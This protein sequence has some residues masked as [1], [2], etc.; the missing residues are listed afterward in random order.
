[1]IFGERFIAGQFSVDKI[2]NADTT[3]ADA[4]S[5][6]SFITTPLPKPYRLNSSGFL[7]EQQDKKVKN[8]NEIN[9]N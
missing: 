3:A 4:I 6:F 7:H 2:I 1:M 9:L 5:K 8:Y